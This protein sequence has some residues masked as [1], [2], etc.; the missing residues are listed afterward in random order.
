[1]PRDYRV[2]LDDILEA[3]ERI[4]AYTD[5]MEKEQFQADS[6]TV[7]AVVRNLEII[8]EASKNIPPQVRALS[9]SVPWSKIAGLRDILI[10]AYFNV[11]ID[12]VWDVVRNKLADLKAAATALLAEDD[13]NEPAS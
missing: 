9:Q 8:G 12:I 3:V 10:H 11:D 2:S 13:T 5:G 7:D 6:K 4:E 1:M